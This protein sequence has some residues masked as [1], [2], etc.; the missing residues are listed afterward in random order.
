MKRIPHLII[1]ALIL[2]LVACQ[3]GPK[4]TEQESTIDPETK[5]SL[6]AEGATNLMS[7]PLACVL[8]EYPNKLGQVV[9]GKEDLREPSD[10]HPSFYGCFDW[11]SAVHGHW[12]MVSLL[13]QFP[14]L[15]KED[16]LAAY[17]RQY[18]ET[19]YHPVGTCKM[20][21]NLNDAGM[22]V[23]DAQLKVH[24]I[25]KL[26]VVDASIMPTITRGNTNAPTIMIAE[27]AADMIL[28]KID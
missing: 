28:G 19:I 6:D 20:G 15:E 14:N 8:K 7:L 22:A 16:E 4:P 17:I 10:L 3:E 24:G 1:A 11:H 2:T 25:E 9:G 21:N 12:S 13:R 23:V 27:K 5:L 18:T 26:R